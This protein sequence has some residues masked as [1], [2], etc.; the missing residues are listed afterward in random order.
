MKACTPAPRQYYP[1]QA[2]PSASSLLTRAQAAAP[3]REYSENESL[4]GAGYF[5]PMA[6]AF[7]PYQV[8][9]FDPA[10]GYFN[11]GTWSPTAAAITSRR[12]MPSSTELD[13]VR[14]LMVQF[15]G[16][17]EQPVPTGSGGGGGGSYGSSRWRSSSYSGRSYD[18]SSSSSRPSTSSSSSSSSS[19]GSSSFFGGFGGR[20]SSSS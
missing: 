13:R 1:Q 4:P 20:S 5:H 9:H 3:L 12:A 7:F 17:E 2:R 8:N 18:S 6:R 11:A 19:S 15:F 16:K 14:G 10:R